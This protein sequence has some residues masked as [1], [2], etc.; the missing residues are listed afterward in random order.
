MERCTI[1][2]DAKLR[3]RATA[4]EKEPYH[5]PLEIREG[6]FHRFAPGIDDN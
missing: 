3:S 1:Y 2:K 4:T 5:F 6:G